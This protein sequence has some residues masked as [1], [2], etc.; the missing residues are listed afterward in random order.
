VSTT[1][2]TANPSAE[3]QIGVDLL[4]PV[5]YKAEAVH[6]VYE[7][8]I[9]GGTDGLYCSSSYDPTTHFE[10]TIAEVLDL[11]KQITGSPVNFET[12]SAE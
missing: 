2:E 12:E 7:P 11:F 5:Q 10:T 9:P 8:V 4:G 6:D 3:L 1:V